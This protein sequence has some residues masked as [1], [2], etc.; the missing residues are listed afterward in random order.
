MAGGACQNFPLLQVI[1]AKITLFPI[2]Y[3]AKLQAMFYFS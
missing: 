1:M 2:F 3:G